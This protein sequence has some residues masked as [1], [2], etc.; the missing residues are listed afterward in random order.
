MRHSHDNPDAVVLLPPVRGRLRDRRLLR[1]LSQGRLEP[2][3]VP[4]DRFAQLLRS[5]GRELPTEGLAALR[6][7]GQSGDRPDAWIAAAD[8]VYMEPRLDRLFLRVP[9][10]GDVSVPELQSLFDVLQGNLGD[11]GSLGFV[12]LGD[13][14]YIRSEQPMVTS[15]VPATSLDGRNPRDWMP[16]AEVAADTL[17][18]VSEIE[19]TLHGQP[20]NVERVSH[21][22]PPVNSLW[23]W[24]GG[25][26]PA[27]SRVPVPPLFADEP[28]LRGYWDSVAGEVDGWPGT[29]EACLDASPAGFVAS[30]SPGPGGDVA[31]D[32]ELAVLRGAVRSGGLRRVVLIAADGLR[33]TLHRGDRIRVW[34]RIAPLLE[35][36]AA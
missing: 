26:A 11:D 18:L 9:G 14:G 36:A 34:R 35:R 2:L 4:V 17:K 15:V 32:A 3:P 25:F 5:L 7:W 8:P 21:G 22:Q 19:M 27:Q 20:V 24:G 6:M 1:W 16:P 23:I 29:I 30:I 13:C 28:L 12:R 31:L 10:P 33:A